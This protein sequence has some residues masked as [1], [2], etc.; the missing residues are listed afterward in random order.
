MLVRYVPP[1]QLKDQL[2]TSH[3]PLIFNTPMP[4]GAAKQLPIPKAAGRDIVNAD[5]GRQLHVKT[6]DVA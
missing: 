2:V 3:K 1:V 6:S 5:E 4:A